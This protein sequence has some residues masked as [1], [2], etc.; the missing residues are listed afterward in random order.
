MSADPKAQLIQ[1]IE[2]QMD[3]FQTTVGRANTNV[4]S[5][6]TMIFNSMGQTI[7]KQYDEIQRLNNQVA[8]LEKKEKPVK[9][10]MTEGS[11]DPIIS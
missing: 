11:P 2:K 1:E 10:K 6:C 4:T 8:N 5:T 9:G 3:L 7:I